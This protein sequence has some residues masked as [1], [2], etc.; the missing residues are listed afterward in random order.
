MKVLIVT[1]VYP[2]TNNPYSGLYVKEQIESIVNIYKNVQF[3]VF[4][5]DHNKGK[6]EYVKSIFKINKHLR[7]HRYDLVHVHY[8]IAGIF[9]L[10]PFLHRIPSIV[11]FHGS[12]IQPK[13]GNGWLSGYI[14][15]MVA[16]SANA[17]VVL[18]NKMQSIV[19]KY[20]DNS[21]IIPCSVDLNLFKNNQTNKPSDK[22]HRP[23]IV[24]PSN[25]ER[26]VKNYPLFC[27]VLNILKNEYGID[28]VEK[29][30]RNMSRIQVA[31]L[32]SKS[33]LLLMTS[34]SEGSPQ[35][36]KE[37]MA[38]NLP[39][40]TTSVGDVNVLLEGVKDCY[41]SKTH[42]ANELAYLA[43]RSL[44]RCGLGIYGREKCLQLGIDSESIADRIY[45][46]YNNTIKSYN[47]KK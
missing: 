37:A 3:D 29:E 8:G 32:F 2:N 17:V 21:E 33:D 34:K 18:N 38:C 12:D 28:A 1:S 47:E 15:K 6:L 45:K 43:K 14:S 41:V 11:T 44:E 7:N 23:V 27:Q 30:I 22:I 19:N 31:D 25:H 9:L 10:Y 5:I 40:V 26:A 4:F 13:G 16:K 24:F 42:D 46:L 20:N 39:C 36:I 35:A